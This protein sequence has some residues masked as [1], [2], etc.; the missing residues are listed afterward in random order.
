LK[1]LLIGCGSSREK[2]MWTTG[3]E[4]WEGLITLDNNPDHNPDVVWDLNKMHLP[5]EDDTFD[6]IHAYDVLEHT[7]QQGDYRFFFKQW[8]GFWRIM[9]PGAL[10][11]GLVPSRNSVWAL[12]DPSHTRIIQKENFIF[13]HQPA[14]ADVGKTPISDFRSI[15]KADFNVGNIRDDGER[16]TFVLQAVKPARLND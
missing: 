3:T 10:F 7:G 1:Q 16:M 13:L 6:E 15:Y 11:F 14:Y 5:F 2:K 8:E 4:K 12:G 9:K